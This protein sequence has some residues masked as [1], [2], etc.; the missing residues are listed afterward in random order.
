MQ[1]AWS[2]ILAEIEA[3]CF[4]KI[5]YR[6]CHATDMT[7]TMTVHYDRS[8]TQTTSPAKSLVIEIEPALPSRISRFFFA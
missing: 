7:S 1:F 2:L 8:A 5:F 4:S 6:A 3:F